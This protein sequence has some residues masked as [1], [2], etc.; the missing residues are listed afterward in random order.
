MNAIKVFFSF[1]LGAFITV[2]HPLWNP[3]TILGILF[4]LDIVAGIIEDKVVN[5]IGFSTKKFLK[6]LYFVA[7]YIVIVVASYVICYLQNDVEEG[8][9]LRKTI[10]Y[11]CSYF[12]FSNITK[13]LHKAYPENRLFSFLY[14]ILS[15]DVI[16]NKIPFLNK[17]L[18]KEGK[19][20]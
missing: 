4:V 19:E 11:V 5:G 6:S 1:I 2:M 18:E 17:F 9:I 10:T 12:Y 3:I 8:M 7:L 20:E 16:T 15:V 13:N 14:F